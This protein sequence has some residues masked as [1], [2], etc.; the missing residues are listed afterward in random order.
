MHSEHQQQQARSA[1][2]ELAEKRQRWVDANI[3][4]AFDEGI[5]KLLTDLYPENAHFIFEILQNAEDKHAS[6]V[7]FTLSD[8]SLVVEHD[9]TQL[10]T[11]TDVDAITSIGKSPKRNDETKIGKFGVGFKSVFAYTNT[12]EVHSGEYHFKIRDLVV[13]D[14]DGVDQAMLSNFTRFIFEFN[15][16][17]K[18]RT[19]AC[20]EIRRGLLEL[21]DA[22]LLFL[23]NIRTVRYS[24]PNGAA[25]SVERIRDDDGRITIQTKRPMGNAS[26]TWLRFDKSIDLIDEE[27]GRRTKNCVIALAYKLERRDGSSKQRTRHAKAV[28]SA[29]WKIVPVETGQV[30][31]Y[32]PAVKEDSRL[33]F[34]VHAPFA[35]TVA[36]DSVRDCLGNS[37]LRDQLV[38]L[39]TDSLVAIRD[40]GLL[41]IDFL[42]VLPL[43]EDDLPLFYQPFLTELRAA[44]QKR[45]LT[46]TLSG[47]HKRSLTLRKGTKEITELLSDHDLASLTNKR[48]LRWADN[49]RRNQR[50]D[51]FLSSVGVEE[52][53]LKDL[54]DAANPKTVS[55]AEAWLRQKTDEWM[56]SLYC[57]L[58]RTPL[59]SDARVAADA[60]PIVRLA[61]G[62]HVQMRTNGE[63]TAYMSSDLTVNNRFKFVSQAVI[64]E[65]DARELFVAAG[66]SEP[67][68]VAEVI[69]HIVP[70]YGSLTCPSAVENSEHV[71]TIVA[72]Y[73][74]DSISKQQRLDNALRKTSFIRCRLNGCG[75]DIY[76]SPEEAYFESADLTVYFENEPSTKIVN[77]AYP[78]AVVELLRKLGVDDLPRCTKGEFGEP[79]YRLR[80]SRGERIENYRLDGLEPLLSGISVECE[81]AVKVKKAAAL[82]RILASVLERNPGCFR[83]KRHFFYWIPKVTEWD[84]EVLSL[85]KKHPWIVTVDGRC[86]RPEEA[87]RDELPVEIQEYA[88]ILELLGLQPGSAPVSPNTPEESDERCQAV[89]YATKLGIDLD[90]A[91]FVRDHREQFAQW[92]RGMEERAENREAL[93]TRT[94]TMSERRNVKLEERRDSAPARESVLAIRSV[95]AYSDSEM[96]AES[97]YKWYRRGDDDKLVCQMCLGRMPFEKKDGDEY[98]EC[99]TLLTKPWA[100]ARKITLK[101]MTPLNIILCPTC[102]SLYKEYVHK[103]VGLQNEIFGQITDGRSGEVTIPCSTLNK[104]ESDRIIHF[105]PTHLAD[106]RVCLRSDGEQVAPSSVI[107]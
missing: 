36:R 81:V 103:D 89:E 59:K 29:D 54:R 49:P 57:R 76:A 69:D 7:S 45:R 79:P 99:V 10:F 72:A 98:S 96:D 30:S 33:R 9:G 8:R 95:A 47:H 3:E 37:S 51:K 50:E 39:A 53:T 27:D 100:D 35:S 28:D 12:P 106:I 94:A 86:V 22:T 6:T 18:P 73:A 14:T 61:D 42:A 55:L 44:F 19:Q 38:T 52:W 90:E 24:L 43:K 60:F 63:P 97:L 102:S 34:C 41:T 80:S 46:P 23:T 83:A 84:S 75:T 56:Q 82:C 11:P 25:G 17:A 68:L 92:R 67:D 5:K 91:E 32:F 66:Y 93:L 101:V 2:A 65:K 13:P 85:L 4:N 16:P 87:S 15:N 64:V 20:E 31:I 21:A 62:A 26:S 70:A 40:K 74:T 77:A 1:L 105:D 71:N 48:F 88:G 78:H 107:R 104:N 58:Q